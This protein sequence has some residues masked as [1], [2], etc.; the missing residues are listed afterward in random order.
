MAKII[1]KEYLE[2][3]F[4]N[5]DVEKVMKR[6]FEEVTVPEHYEVAEL[7]DSTEGLIIVADGTLQDTSTEI[8]EATVLASLLPE[9]D[10]TEFAVGVYVKLVPEET[11]EQS[12][13]LPRAEGIELEVEDEDI[14]FSLF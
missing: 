1:N 3:Q 14:D 10:P 2:N 13:Y 9:A 4:K 11:F 12:I 8:E 5:Y 6:L 7:Q